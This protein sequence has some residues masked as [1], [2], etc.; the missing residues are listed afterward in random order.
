MEFLKL[1]Y[2]EFKIKRVKELPVSGAFHTSFMRLGPMNPLREVLKKVELKKPRIPTYSNVE[3]VPYTSIPQMSD[4]LS[5]QIY[6]PVKWEQIVHKIYDKK[7]K[8]GEG[9]VF[10]R[11]LK[12]GNAQ[13]VDE[14]VVVENAGEPAESVENEKNEKKVDVIEDDDFYPDT[15]E[16]GPGE[17]LGTMLR[18]IHAKAHRFYKHIDV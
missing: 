8:Q 4:L 10:K 17:Q 5:K 14:N 3:A 1:N 16:C 18:A 7:N 12:F 11:S 13:N 9:R 2:R 15:Y 6:K